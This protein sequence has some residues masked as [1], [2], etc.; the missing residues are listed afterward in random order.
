KPCTFATPA[1]LRICGLRTS[2]FRESTLMMKPWCGYAPP[3]S[4]QATPKACS[5][6]FQRRSLLEC[7]EGIS[8][9]SSWKVRQHGK[10][11][12][13]L[14]PVEIW[15]LGEMVHMHSLYPCR[16]RPWLRN[17]ISSLSSKQ[18]L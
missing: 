11:K 16:S 6:R 9:G 17:P 7:Q 1:R 12:K 4:T 13:F 8:P 15:G 5:E 10:T 2:K 3:Q 14:E 18:L